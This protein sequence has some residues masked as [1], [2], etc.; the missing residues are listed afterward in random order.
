M[1]NASATATATA[2]KTATRDRQQYLTQYA[3]LVKRIAH[4]MMAKLPASVEID[5]IIQTGMLGLLDAIGRYE[6][7][8]GAQFETYAAQR[9]RG[10]IL[11][12][13]RQADWL[14]RSFRRDLRRIEGAIGKLEQ[15]LSRAPTEHE[16]AGELGI[17][18]PAYQKMLQ[19]ARGYQLI[20]FE[21]FNHADG[22]DYLER[23]CEDKR[24]NPLDALLDRK[25]RERLVE[26][27]A[28]L[29]EREKTVMGLYYEEELNFRE[30]G[31]TLGVS[32]SRI[33]QLHSQAIARLRSQIRNT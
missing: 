14:P 17:A 32:E 20:S 7:S 33:C 3:P 25:L 15:R 27:I 6:E 5:D 19:D 2:T 11:D 1:Y 16:V 12:G 29:P 8:H 13:L 10:A 31:E 4:H 21:D 23:H 24:A 18:L 30:I 22:S 9:I 28:N 26:G